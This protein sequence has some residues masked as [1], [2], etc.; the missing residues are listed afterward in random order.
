MY[1]YVC[2]RYFY[3]IILNFCLLFCFLMVKI[4]TLYNYIIWDIH[5]LAVLAQTLL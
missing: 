4:S 2:K 3:L 5:I 1:T